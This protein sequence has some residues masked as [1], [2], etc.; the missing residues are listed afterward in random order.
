MLSMKVINQKLTRNRIMA[1]A[2]ASTIIILI[3]AIVLF[4]YPNQQSLP[5]A[6]IIDQVSSSTVFPDSRLPNETFIAGAEQLLQERFST[7]DYYSENAT[8][9]NYKALP[10]L[11][12]KLILWRAHSALDLTSKYI[13]ISTSE[14]NSSKTYEFSDDQLT[15]CSIVGDPYYYWSITPNFIEES[16]DGRF[17]DTIIILMSCNG[18][19]SEYEKTAE[20]F[21]QKG[22]MVFISWDGWIGS[23]DN[24]EAITLLLQDLIL[25]NNTIK[26]AVENAPSYDSPIY[27][28]SK[29]NYYPQTEVGNYRI[30]NYDEKAATVSARVVAAPSLRQIDIG[31]SYVNLKIKAD[32]SK[33]LTASTASKPSKTTGYEAVLP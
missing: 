4:Y 20:A 15:L 27:G 22:A 3:A 2:T 16:M 25:Q 10:S 29:L 13:A 8:V 21:I 9:D 7:V 31:F 26:E 5:K 30:P 18:L 19:K 14:N 12:Y 1:L 23:S 32:V 6:A 33:W 11:G 17:E 28:P 24:D